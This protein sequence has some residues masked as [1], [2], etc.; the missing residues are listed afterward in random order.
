VGKPAGT[1]G[2]CAEHAG[3][4]AVALPALRDG[5]RIADDGAAEQVT[6]A[7]RLARQYAVATRA[8]YAVTLTAT[9]IRF[10]CQSGCPGGAPSTPSTPILHEATLATSL[11]PVQFLPNGSAQAAAEVTVTSPGAAVQRVCVSV[12]GR[13]VTAAPGAA[14]P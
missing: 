2:A 1:S 7:M 3:R 5:F 13:I 9:T 10:A 6:T 11:N 8:T 4:V 12:P 14:C